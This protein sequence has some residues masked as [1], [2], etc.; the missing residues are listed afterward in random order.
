MQIVDSYPVAVAMWVVTRLCWGAWAKT[1]KLASKEWHFHL[2]FLTNLSADLPFPF[3]A[4][5]TTHFNQNPTACSWDHKRVS[6]PA[7]A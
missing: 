2:V 6:F 1:Q 4:P 3:S 7:F 5:A